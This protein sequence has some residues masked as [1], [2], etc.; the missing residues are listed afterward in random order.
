MH[1]Q[2]S[3]LEPTIV[4]QGKVH[5]ELCYVELKCALSL[6]PEAKECTESNIC[7]AQVPGELV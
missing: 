3:D 4:P 1:L 7:L 2:D 6:V 5:I